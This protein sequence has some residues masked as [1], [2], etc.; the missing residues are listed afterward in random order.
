MSATLTPYIETNTSSP[1]L[2]GGECTGT[3]LSFSITILATPVAV[4]SAS[5]EVVCT[6]DAPQTTVTLNPGQKYLV[7][8]SLISGSASGFTAIS[9]KNSGD[10]IESG[11]LINTSGADAVVR[12]VITPYNLVPIH[13]MT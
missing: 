6:G 3:V 10:V 9:A 4:L 12:Y 2:D 5:A 1:G 7:T 13:R 8:A 11:N